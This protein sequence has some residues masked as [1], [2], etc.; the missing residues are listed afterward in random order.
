MKFYYV[1]ILECADQSLYVGVTNNIERRV[2]QHNEG[3]GGYFTSK[4]LPAKLVFVEEVTDINYAIQREKQIKGWRRAKKQAL[5]DSKFKQ[6]Q[7]LSKSY[8]S[9]GSA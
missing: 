3:I 5:I 2:S 9:T 1:Y 6:L 4:R 7:I 8:A